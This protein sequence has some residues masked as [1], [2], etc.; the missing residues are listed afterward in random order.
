MSDAPSPPDAVAGRRR[1]RLEVAAVFV[2][3][4]IVYLIAPATGIS[5]SNYTMLF[6]HQLWS[7]GT[8]DVRE[9]VP[10]RAFTLGGGRFPG[11]YLHRYP[12]HLRIVGEGGKPR[13]RGRPWS[14]LPTFPVGSPLLG[15][16]FAAAADLAGRPVVDPELGGYR[17]ERD[18]Q[19]QYTAAA[20]FT[21]A[22]VAAAFAALRR[23]VDRGPALAASLCLAFGS[24][25][26][27]T[28]SKALWSQTSCLFLAGLALPGIVR[29]ARGE[30]AR[31]EAVGALLAGAWICRPTAALMVAAVGVWILARD[32]R[33]ALRFGAGAAAVA[34][35][36]VAWSMARFGAPMPPYYSAGR[37]GDGFSFESIYGSLLAANRGL[38]VYLPVVGVL[39]AA[40][41]ARR[42]RSHDGGLAVLALAG[43]GA[44]W[45][46]VV[47]FRHWWGGY[48]FGPRLFTDALFWIVLLAAAVLPWIAGAEPAVRRWRRA[49][50]ATAAVG[51]VI[52]AGGAL[53]H[54]GMLWNAR[55]I[56]V[57][58]APE[59]IWDW[60]DPQWLAFANREPRRIVMPEPVE[61]DS[62]DAKQ[63]PKRARPDRERRRQRRQRR[64]VE[65]RPAG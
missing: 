8:L 43:L 47:S 26:W 24:M 9:H 25:A 17:I 29:I 16:P 11:P 42:A 50:V 61:I 44:H 12:Y 55:P 4:A 21:A 46:T 30:P 64:P 14:L 62:G 18:R 51:V 3:V 19:L 31:A 34:L 41:L 32:R 1:R 10:E 36:F 13:R 45:L 6:A 38:L 56:P 7:K 15:V 59:R 37:L 35:P 52:H 33:A 5:D 53:S 20:L 2:G 54:Q 60:R 63:V 28:A 39:V 58:R 40:A 22:F 65:P 27:S 23:G 57:D 48:S 49:L